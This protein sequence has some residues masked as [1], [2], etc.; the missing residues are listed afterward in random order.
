MPRRRTTCATS[1]STSRWGCADR[2]DLH[3]GDRR[4]DHT[5]TRRRGRRRR[6]GSEACRPP[7]LGT[8][9]GQRR[10]R[11]QRPRRRGH[12]VASAEPLTR[13]GRS[14]EPDSAQL[15]TSSDPRGL[16]PHPPRTMQIPLEDPRSNC[17]S[18]GRRRQRYVRAVISRWRHYG[19]KRRTRF[20]RGR[21]R[22][23]LRRIGLVATAHLGPTPRR[24][25]VPP[26][27]QRTEPIA[28]TIAA[29]PHSRRAGRARNLRQPG[30]SAAAC[31]FARPGRK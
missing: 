16:V 2:A 24:T 19:R 22:R 17:R 14:E 28:D 27:F 6:R 25:P 18:S 5:R 13:L 3:R 12:R 1:T 30:G 11:G 9:V 26:V 8:A 31:R 23:R 7:C 20:R 10:A 21:Q 15:P 29:E 4:A